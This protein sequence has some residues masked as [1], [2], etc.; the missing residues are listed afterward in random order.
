MAVTNEY[1]VLIIQSPIENTAE[2]E[3]LG[4]E[5][6]GAKGNEGIKYL[7]NEVEDEDDT[8]SK[9]QGI[10]NIKTPMFDPSDFENTKKLNYYI[11]KNFQKEKT[12]IPEEL[13]TFA[14]YSK[15]RRYARLFE[16]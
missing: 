4:Y 13:S 15:I 10:H 2:K 9:N 3:F 12:Y 11:R 14:K 16:Y 6:S 7:G 5:W 1:P 8:I